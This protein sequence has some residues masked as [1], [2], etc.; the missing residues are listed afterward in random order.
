MW[1]IQ[2]YLPILMENLFPTC[3]KEYCEYF[4]ICFFDLN[5][6]C[7]FCRCTCELVDL[8]LFFQKNLRLVWRTNVPFAC[9]NRC[10]ELCARYESERYSVC[11][12]KA[13]NLHALIHIP[14]QDV[15]LRCNYCLGLLTSSEKVDLTTRGRYCWLVRGH[16]RAIC[17]KCSQKEL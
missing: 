10:L 7:I 8:A 13:E 12:V 6:K 4:G 9:C 11:S 2:Q 17:S 14:L 1:Q 15:L 3:L 16:W 5:L